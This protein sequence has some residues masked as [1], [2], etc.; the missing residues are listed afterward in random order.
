[1]YVF[2]GDFSEDFRHQKKKKKK[3]ISCFAPLCVSL[4][5]V[6]QIHDGQLFQTECFFKINIV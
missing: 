4:S 3:K 1:M 5:V 6:K 2:M